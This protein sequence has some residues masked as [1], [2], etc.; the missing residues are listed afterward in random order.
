MSRK[1]VEPKEA[2]RSKVIKSGNGAVIK[3]YKKY[4]GKNATVIIESKK[5]HR[6]NDTDDIAE[7]AGAN[8]PSN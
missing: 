7:H 8:W 1:S 2:Y 3:S 4:I 6:G 5:K